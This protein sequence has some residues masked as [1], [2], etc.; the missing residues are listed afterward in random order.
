L[1]ERF[2]PAIV[3]QIE[4]RLRLNGGHRKQQQQQQQQWLVGRIRQNNLATGNWPDPNRIGGNFKLWPAI[5]PN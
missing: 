3:M 5:K 4:Q 1:G 2:G